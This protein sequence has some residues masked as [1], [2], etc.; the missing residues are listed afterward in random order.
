MIIIIIKKNINY[1]KYI[2]N[3]LSTYYKICITEYPTGRKGLAGF[4]VSSENNLLILLE[5]P[6][7]CSYK[8][9]RPWKKSLPEWRVIAGTVGRWGNEWFDW[10][11]GSHKDQRDSFPSSL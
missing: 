3:I 7:Q 5:N 6:V 9:L 2:F 11:S 8:A 4:L 1:N 10:P